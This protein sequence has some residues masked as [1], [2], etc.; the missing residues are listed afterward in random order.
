VRFVILYQIGKLYGK[1]K[2]AATGATTANGC[3]TTGLF[4]CDMNI[5]RP[6]DFALV[7]GNTN[8]APVNHYALVKTNDQPSFCSS[9]FL[10]FTSADALRSSDINPVPSLN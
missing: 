7:S 3:R 9:I 10:P 5:F 6:H 2:Q 4:L 1:Y 8:A